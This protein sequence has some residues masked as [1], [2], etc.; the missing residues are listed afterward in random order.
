MLLAKRVKHYGEGSIQALVSAS[1]LALSYLEMGDKAQAM[2]YFRLQGRF[3]AKLADPTSEHEAQAKAWYTYTDIFF[4]PDPQL[5][6]DML[7]ALMG[8]KDWR[9]APD[10]MRVKASELAA[11]EY[12]RQGKVRQGLALRQAAMRFPP[13]ASPPAAPSRSM[14]C[15][16]SPAPMCAIR[17][18]RRRS[19]PSAISIA[20]SMTGPCARWARRVTAL[21]RRNH[22]R[23]GGQ[24]PL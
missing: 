12:E 18:R 4:S 6:P 17:S 15:W 22:A 5:K 10:L 1:N 11:K 9:S 3:G 8:L 21:H 2:R 16:G 24:F 14:R 20:S 7:E 19:P 13:P 23:A